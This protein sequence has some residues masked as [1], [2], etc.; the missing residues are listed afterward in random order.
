MQG[1]CCSCAAAVLHA[2][3]RTGSAN[4]PRRRRRWMVGWGCQGL[5]VGSGVLM[6]VESIS[7]CRELRVSLGVLMISRK[8]RSRPQAAPLAPLVPL[9]GAVEVPFVI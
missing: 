6:N 9:R 7:P 8:S 4:A 3:Q 5:L 2:V 1:P